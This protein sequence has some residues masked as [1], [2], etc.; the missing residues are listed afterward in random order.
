MA[1]R[2]DTAVREI[3]TRT[4]VACGDKRSKDEL[5]RFVRCQNGA[6]ELDL[7]GNRPG[8]GAYVCSLACFDKACK[9]KR[10]ARSLRANDKGQAWDELRIILSR[11]LRE[12]E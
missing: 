3:R 8:R 5:V 2:R 7:S 9:Q 10:L 4:C 12:S 11:V 6:I 1:E